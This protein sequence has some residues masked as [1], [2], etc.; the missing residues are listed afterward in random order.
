MWTYW[1]P[2]V[3]ALLAADI[4]VCWVSLVEGTTGRTSTVI[5]VEVALEISS[6]LLYE[7]SLDLVIEYGNADLNVWL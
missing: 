5:E 6:T 3:I 7:G 2:V 4:N 1:P